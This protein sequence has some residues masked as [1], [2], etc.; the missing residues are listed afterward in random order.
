M[1]DND[2]YE[3]VGLMIAMLVFALAILRN[4]KDYTTEGK[5]MVLLGI[6]VM[7]AGTKVILSYLPKEKG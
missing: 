6:A 3:N 7:L 2:L 1:R 5:A 4:W